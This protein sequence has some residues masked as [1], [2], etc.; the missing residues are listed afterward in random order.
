MNGAAEKKK[1]T[2]EVTG[3]CMQEVLTS[4]PIL[5]VSN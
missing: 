3:L 2:V 5:Q 4:F 1:M